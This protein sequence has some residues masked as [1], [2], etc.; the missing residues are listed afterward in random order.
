MKSTLLEG[1]DTIPKEAID[2]FSENILKIVSRSLLKGADKR[3]AY[4]RFSNMGS[5]C[6]RKLWY[7]INSPEDKE[8]LS[9]DVLLKFLYGHLIEAFIL[10]LAEVSGHSVQGTQDEASLF[11]IKGHRDAVI[12]GVVVDVKSTSS[13]SYKKFAEGRLADDDPFGYIPQLQGYLKAGED[14]PLVLDKNRA[15]FLPVDKTL[16][17]FC[18]DFHEKKDWDWEKILDHKKEIISQPEP[19]ERG[20]EPEPMGKSGNMQLGTFCSY[21]NFK[22]KC[23]PELRTFIYSSGPAFLTKVVKE[24]NV[25][26]A[27]KTNT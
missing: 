26:E 17:H 2:K 6:E 24:P 19:P 25:Y 3:E 14:D 7:E 15:A 12:D 9:A 20:F 21:C 13:F 1:V 11:G 18:L 5:P 4:L 8:E 22:E 10:L 23:Y 27:V 16:G